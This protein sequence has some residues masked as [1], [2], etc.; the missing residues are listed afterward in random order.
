MFNF[1][2]KLFGV[3]EP[4]K[5]ET[6]VEVP[7]KVE[8]QEPVSAPVVN[9]VQEIVEVKPVVEEVK[10]TEGKKPAKKPAKK[11]S[12]AAITAKPKTSTSKT[13]RTKKAK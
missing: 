11:P 6:T 10:P 12:P 5:K 13:P 7:Y 8:V 1:L 2:K 4:E 3:Y 9:A